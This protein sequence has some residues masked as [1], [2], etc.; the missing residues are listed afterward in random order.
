MTTYKN[1]SEWC[2]LKQVYDAAAFFLVCSIIIL[3]SELLWNKQGKVHLRR[4]LVLEPSRL[5][6]HCS[7]ACQPSL[8]AI[9]YKILYLDK[10]INPTKILIGS[11]R[12]KNLIQNQFNLVAGSHGSYIIFWKIRPSYV[13]ISFQMRNT[14]SIKWYLFIGSK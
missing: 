6:K 9:G 10:T 13:A 12:T 11:I 7:P 1:G 8:W 14:L 3:I 5:S 2:K 4:V